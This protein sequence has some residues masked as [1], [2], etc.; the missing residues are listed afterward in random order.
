M[1]VLCWGNSNINFCLPHQETIAI[2]RDMKGVLKF[3]CQL[4]CLL[5]HCSEA[6]RRSVILTMAQNVG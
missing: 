3:I 5:E 4:S 2:A 6:S 1:I